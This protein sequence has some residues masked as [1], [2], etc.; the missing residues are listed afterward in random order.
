VFGCVGVRQQPPFAFP[1]DE[2]WSEG[3]LPECEV[4]SYVT[5][6]AWIGALFWGRDNKSDSFINTASRVVVGDDFCPNSW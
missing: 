1:R 2:T 6:S 5:L 3:R 4:S